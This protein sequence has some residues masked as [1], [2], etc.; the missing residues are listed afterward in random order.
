MC[1][2][3]FRRGGARVL[4]YMDDLSAVDHEVVLSRSYEKMYRYA[5]VSERGADGVEASG[6]VFVIAESLA[7]ILL[8]DLGAAK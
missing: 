7:S 8:E 5:R 1:C 2:R 3:S 6:P 4:L